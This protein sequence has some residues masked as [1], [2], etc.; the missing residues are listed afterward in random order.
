M[1]LIKWLTVHHCS[2]SHMNSIPLCRVIPQV[3]IGL[4]IEPYRSNDV[5][6]KHLYAPRF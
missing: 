1:L 6:K 4:K 5:K 2:F 3:G